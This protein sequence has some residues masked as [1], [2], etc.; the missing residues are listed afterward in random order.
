MFALKFASYAHLILKM[1]KTPCNL[2]AFP[3]G[4]FSWTEMICVKR[5]T[6]CNSALNVV[7]EGGKHLFAF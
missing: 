2:R 7:F 3:W 6:L 1:S 4:K 5:L